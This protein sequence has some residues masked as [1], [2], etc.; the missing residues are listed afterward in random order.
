MLLV[1]L[2][3]GGAIDS[4]PEVVFLGATA[5]SLCYSF[6]IVLQ[7]RLS[8]PT[9]VARRLALVLTL[10]AVPVLIDPRTAEVI[11][12]GRLFLLV[13]VAVVLIG[14]WGLEWSWTRRLP[15]WRHGLHWPMLAVA[16][17]VVVATVASSDRRLSVL[18][19]YGSYQGLVLILAFIVLAFGLADSFDAEDI[20]V[21]ARI[22]VAGSVPVVVYALIQ[23]HDKLIGG[24]HWDFIGWTSTY[25]NVFATLGNP[26][27]LAGYLVTI[28]PLIVLSTQGVSRRVQWVWAGLGLVLVAVILQTAARGAWLALVVGGLILLVAFRRQLVSSARNVAVGAGV[29]VAGAVL[30]VLGARS[31]IGAKFAELFAAG[32]NSSVSQRYGYWRAAL[33]IGRHHLL[34]G[35]G[36]DTY[37]IFYTR[38]QDAALVRALGTSFFVNGAHNLFMDALSNEGVPGL[39]IL[40]VLLLWAAV[41]VLRT[42]RSSVPAGGQATA[43][44][45]TPSGALPPDSTTVATAVCLGAGLAAYV[46]QESFDVAQV[47]T[48]FWLWVLLGL[49]GSLLLSTR[50]QV[51]LSGLPWATADGHS[52]GAGRARPELESLDLPRPEDSRARRSRRRRAPVAPR[53]AAGVV[54]VVLIGVAVWA[55]GLPWRA[56]HD[57]W[58]AGRLSSGVTGAQASSSVDAQI[59]T[60]LSRARSLNPWE[61]TYDDRLGELA[62]QSARQGTGRTAEDQAD[63]SAALRYLEAGYRTQPD[64][65][66]A[67]EDYVIGL[68]YQA[69][70]DPSPSARAAAIQAARWA[71]NDDPRDPQAQSNL[72][73][74]ET[75]SS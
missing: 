16:G 54:G 37:S 44:P 29:I 7:R 5:W 15:A 14:I 9:L 46:V 69:E 47:G 22:I 75:A 50:S 71:L 30:L 4:V 10:V 59:T 72:K 45:T 34:T 31:F 8:E 65:E 63:L 6:S 42:A 35:T 56:D 53:V 55:V 18:G 70:L 51:E 57:E 23:M 19:A 64:N 61:P 74:A 52:T 2:R 13:L 27:H 49:L 32:A 1:L 66:Q 41:W 20:P 25:H 60:D 26:N 43:V 12:L 73:K 58:A 33:A 62:L 48:T 36:P 40:V 3:A 68:I 11:N 21:L 67:A 39:A 24:R 38:Y 28:L 17:W